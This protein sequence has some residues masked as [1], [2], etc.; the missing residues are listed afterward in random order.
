MSTH[1]GTGTKDVLSAPFKIGNQD[2][3]LVD[4]PGF[5]DTSI[6][7]TKILMRIGDWLKDTYEEGL[8]CPGSSI[9]TI[10][11]TLAWTAPR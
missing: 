4:T 2:V 7:D 1:V 10:F 3:I 8:F 11:Q 5:D 9:C 6:T